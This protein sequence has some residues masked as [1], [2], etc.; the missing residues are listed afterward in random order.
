M[1]AHMYAQCDPAHKN[2]CSCFHFLVCSSGGNIL[3]IADRVQTLPL[4]SQQAWQ[5]PFSW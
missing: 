2:E 3:E 1:Q 4:K 5:Q